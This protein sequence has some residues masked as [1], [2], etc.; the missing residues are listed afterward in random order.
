MTAGRRSSWV[1]IGLCIEGLTPRPSPPS[2]AR[3]TSPRPDQAHCGRRQ[4]NR[5]STVKTIK[6]LPISQQIVLVVA[7]EPPP[8]SSRGL[9]ASRLS[10]YVKQAC[11]HGLM[12]KMPQSEFDDLLRALQDVGFSAVRPRW[13]ARVGG[14]APAPSPAS[15]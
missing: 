3:P 15:S 2:T 5:N 10:S 9:H 1:A 6:E 8:V 14:G 13:R 11:R 7:S 12:D 4:P